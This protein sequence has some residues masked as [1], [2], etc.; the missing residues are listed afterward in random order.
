MI[1]HKI[2]TFLS[3]FSLDEMNKLNDFV[4]SP[5][6]NKNKKLK[7]LFKEI[8]KYYPEFSDDKLNIKNLSSKL[9]PNLKQNESTLRH[10]FADLMKI[11]EEFLLF[12][13][14][15][16]TSID[17]KL[18]LL[19]SLTIKNEKTEFQKLLKN[20]NKENNEKGVDSIYFYNRNKLN[21]SQFNFNIINSNTK[22]P[23]IIEEN[24]ESLNSY[25]I[26]FVIY[27]ITEFVNVGL[28]LNIYNS[29]FKINKNKPGAIIIFESLDVSK[30]VAIIES[31]DKNNF[32]LSIYLNLYYAFKYVENLNHYYKYKNLVIKYSERMSNDEI[33]YH[34]SMLISY[35][36][37][38]TAN[39]VNKEEFDTELF[40]IYNI[41]LQKN[42]FADSKIKYLNEDLY[43]NIL[44]LALRLNKASWILNFIKSYSKYLHP[45][46][47]ENFVKLSFA[48]YY[49]HR[50]NRKKSTGDLNKAFN[51]LK[52]I[53][54]E[55]FIVKYDIKSL[56]LKIFYDLKYNEHLITQINNY[57]KFLKRNKLVTDKRKKK[58]K[59]FLNIVEKLVY[60]RSGDSRTGITDLKFNIKKN[61]DIDHRD[62]LL[63]KSEEL[64]MY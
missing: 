30:I 17:K 34:F 42:H 28:N 61:E 25:L 31:E 2:F 7:I 24:R 1:N 5:Y 46:K 23:I 14:I 19:K 35:C 37:L 54:E 50:G 53:Q 43:R 40:K 52:E 26:N 64:D 36:I 29:K 4:D 21:I 45:V 22:S 41:F 8:K 10:L 56:Y 49:Y 47:K 38:K 11:T 20:L 59:S 44:K 48:E 62:W 6:H 27:F 57:R 16:K 55:S 9:N 39:N 51:F 63:K 3:S 18:F 33:A 12:E 58:I 32:I 60:F 13:E 15:N